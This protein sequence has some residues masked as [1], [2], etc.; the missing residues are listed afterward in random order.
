MLK[1]SLSQ[2]YPN[3]F[4]HKTFYP[5]IYTHNTHT[6]KKRE[7]DRTECLIVCFER[8]SLEYILENSDQN[9]Y[10][11]AYICFTPLMGQE[12]LL[13]LPCC[14]ELTVLSNFRGQPMSFKQFPHGKI[15]QNLP[16]K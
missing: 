8:A 12:I 11:T 15:I 9:H 6:M 1:T 2:H 14:S 7:E 10:D 13:A 3:M 4:D 5:Y 16:N